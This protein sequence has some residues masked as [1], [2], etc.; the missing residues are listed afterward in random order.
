VRKR[1]AEELL[2][3]R[4]GVWWLPRF[5][6]RLSVCLDRRGGRLLAGCEREEHAQNQA[7]GRQPVDPA[8][9]PCQPDLTS[10]DRTQ[11][12]SRTHSSPF[13]M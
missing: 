2:L 11:L 7:A 3:K 9:H 12:G 10:A 1:L 4:C 5:K 6:Q 8:T 13:D